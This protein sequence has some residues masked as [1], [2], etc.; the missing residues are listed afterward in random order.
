MGDVLEP[1]TFVIS[2]PRRRNRR[3]DHQVTDEEHN[4]LANQA[5]DEFRGAARDADLGASLDRVAEEGGITPAERG[6][7]LPPARRATADSQVFAEET[8]QRKADAVI[9]FD[10][11]V[12]AVAGRD[13]GAGWWNQ[14][15][16]ELARFDAPS[17]KPEGEAAPAVQASDAA[18]IE[19]PRQSADPVDSHASNS[20][21][22][23][24]SN[25]DVERRPEQAAVTAAH[26]PSAQERGTY[27]IDRDAI[28]RD[29]QARFTA[30]RRELA[31]AQHRRRVGTGLQW[32]LRGLG[33]I[34]AATGA[35]TSNP[36]LAGIGA[37]TSGMSR[38]IDPER[39]MREVEE[40]EALRDAYNTRWQNEDER[41]ARTQDRMEGRAL[42][43]AH[44]QVYQNELRERAEDH[45]ATRRQR[46]DEARQR[47]EEFNARMKADHPNANAA[48]A[49]F[50]NAVERY[51]QATGGSAAD[52]DDV[53]QAIQTI[54]A[55]P[56]EAAINDVESYT[57]KGRRRAGGSGRGT[58]E[59]TPESRAILIADVA[60][61]TGRTPE[62]VAATFPDNRHGN[63]RLRTEA[64][65]LARPR[66]H[67]NQPAPGE[68]VPLDD[69]KM[70][71]F[72]HDFGP[73]YLG[74]ASLNSVNRRLGR[75]NS[76]QLSAMLAGR[77]TAQAAGVGGERQA[78]YNLIN[79]YY[80]DVSGA[81]VSDGEA[82]RYMAAL[83][84]DDAVDP[85]AFVRWLRTRIDETTAE[86]DAQ[87]A[88][89][90]QEY[91]DEWVRRFHA[92]RRARQ[93]ARTAPQGGAQ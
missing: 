77:R 43:R 73:I 2:A 88:R 7:D 45:T 85:Q 60:H 10:P 47:G 79:K 27:E 26:A 17:R 56:I 87:G 3:A 61:A 68:P 66:G 92:Q 34:L 71:R 57:A 64:A 48:R 8:P 40:N 29:R 36:A 5:I 62:Q 90:G 12:D 58:P 89:Y 93:A 15:M 72:G 41:L 23:T 1:G 46:A 4:S 82:E 9:D 74:N 35:G 67:G 86:L 91:R 81:A 24:P 32:G 69:R 44:E 38:A 25:T 49:R 65:T 75:L 20:P 28:N 16:D 11:Q 52:F 31:E 37:M 78:V 59:T 53:S 42:Q 76:A 30:A 18:H 50:Q 21:A 54:G 80:H 55:E 39:K 33:A 6:A 13:P 84:G 22:A 70:E 83:G 14:P 51:V 19:E 63:E